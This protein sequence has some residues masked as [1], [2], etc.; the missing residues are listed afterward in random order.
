VTPS[1]AAP[2]AAPAVAPEPRIA[3][4]RR[5][6]TLD[7]RHRR[8]RWVAGVLVVATVIAA[9]WGL[10]RSPLLDVNDIVVTGTQTLDVDEVRDAGGLATG[11]PMVSVDPASVESGIGDL[12]QVA[13]VSVQRSW[14]DGVVTVEVTERVAVAAVEQADDLVVVDV[15]GFVVG[16]AADRAGLPLVTGVGQLDPG[17]VLEG[18]DLAAVSVAASLTPGLASNVA[19]IGTTAGVGV[20]AR[21]ADGGEVLVGDPQDLEVKVRTMQTVLAAVD[22][23][24]LAQL[25]VRVPGNAVLTRDPGCA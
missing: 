6:V 7:K 2:T 19:A 21:L 9:V 20:V 14:R 11:M 5:M 24:C 22:L 25:D 16:R 18:D 4:R 12:P 23:S 13:A 3:E 15:S 8:R 10:T 17:S 1:P